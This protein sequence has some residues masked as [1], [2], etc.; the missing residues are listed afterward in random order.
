MIFVHNA[1]GDKDF[2]KFVSTHIYQNL[3]IQHGG[4][5]K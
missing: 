1:K 3:K 4:N 5:K 2:Q